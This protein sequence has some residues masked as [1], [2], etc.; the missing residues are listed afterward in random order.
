MHQF[1]V[2]DWG[3]SKRDGLR[4]FLKLRSPAPHTADQG[5]LWEGNHDLLGERMNGGEPDVLRCVA[6]RAWEN[7]G[8]R[9]SRVRCKLS[10]RDPSS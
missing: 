2:L 1:E 8:S 9:I 5:S 4:I 7:A 10:R 6:R 3:V